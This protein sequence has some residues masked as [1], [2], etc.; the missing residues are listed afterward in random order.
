MTSFVS[1][2]IYIFRA[3]LSWIDQVSHFY[4]KSRTLPFPMPF[5]IFIG[6]HQTRF[7]S[8]GSFWIFFAGIMIFIERPFLLLFLLALLPLSQFSFSSK[9]IINQRLLYLRIICSKSDLKV[10]YV[11]FETYRSYA[12]RRDGDSA[13]I[14][15]DLKWLY[16]WRHLAPS[17]LLCSKH[18]FIGPSTKVFPEMSWC[19]PFF[20]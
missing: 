9:K 17:C 18:A 14:K 6:C 11:P 15:S 10:S 19:F 3:K 2:F 7:I 12:W 4:Y 16:L 1:F 8:A 5:K 13:N 20:I